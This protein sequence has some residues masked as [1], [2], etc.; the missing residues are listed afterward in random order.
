MHPDWETVLRQA[1]AAIEHTDALHFGQPQEELNH[2][3]Q[4]DIISPLTQYGL[5]EIQGDDKTEFCQGQ[6][7]SDVA[8]ISPERSQLN[9]YCSPKGRMLACFRIFQFGDSYYLRLPQDTLDT[10]LKRLRMFVL[11]AKVIL[12]DGSEDILGFGLSGP[13]SVNLLTEYLGQAAPIRVNQA[14]S[15]K[16]LSV[17]RV[18]GEHPR[19]EL[20]GHFEPIRACWHA[21]SQRTQAVGTQAWTLLNIRAGLP[22]VYAA[23]ADAFVPQMANLDLLGGL[24][25]KKG[26]YVGQEIVARMH[27]LGRLKRRMFR[28][29]LDSGTIPSPGTDL[30]AP[31]Q[32]GEQSVGQIVS[33]AP[34]PVDGPKGSCEA[35]AVLVLD[36]IA[37]ELQLAGQ[38]AAHIERL[39][40]PYSLDAELAAGAT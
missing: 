18:A 33:A 6:F 1:G 11:R 2:A 26:C 35:L 29:R 31:A 10:S 38:P 21:L 20:Y 7:T 22:E 14:L 24:S 9:A 16:G 34:S 12:S 17:I 27:Y 19:F 23:T 36:C 39:D 8:Q 37:S 32:R 28:L 15:G 30:F 4:A 5:I 3:L 13:N 40:L 25:F